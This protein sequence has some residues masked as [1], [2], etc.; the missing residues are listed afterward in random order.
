MD[1]NAASQAFEKITCNIGA[2]AHGH[3][4]DGLNQ[5]REFLSCLKK[6]KKDFLKTRLFQKPKS[7]DENR[8]RGIWENQ[9]VAEQN[10]YP[11]IQGDIVR[12]K[13]VRFPSGKGSIPTWPPTD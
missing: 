3:C 11:F 13:N 1:T 2:M 5:L 9:T 8:E 7:W 10:K 12:S 6:R 4:G